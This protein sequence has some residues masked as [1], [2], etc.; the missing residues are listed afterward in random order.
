MSDNKMSD[1]KMPQPRSPFREAL[2]SN[3]HDN[4]REAEAMYDST[5]RREIHEANKA[6]S[7]KAPT[8]LDRGTDAGEGPTGPGGDAVVTGNTGKP[9][10]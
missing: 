5:G 4:A 7:E 8:N 10:V 9:L 2:L 3:P 1:N 6:L